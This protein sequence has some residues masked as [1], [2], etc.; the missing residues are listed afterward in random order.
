[1]DP[2]DPHDQVREAPRPGPRRP[3]G[4][5]GARR[6][7]RRRRHDEGHRH[8]RRGQSHDGDGAHRADGPEAAGSDRHPRLQRVQRLRDRR[9]GAAGGLHGHQGRRGRDGPRLRRR[10]ARRRGPPGR[11]GPLG[12]LQ[13]V[14]AARPL[15]RRGRRGR[16]HRDRDHAGRLRPD[17]H[18]VRAQVRRDQ[19]RAL[20]QDQREEPRP[21]DAEPARG[22]HEEDVARRDHERRHDRL[23]QHRGRCARPTATGRRRPWSC[24]APS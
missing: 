3:G 1:M 15:R 4:G 24:R 6:A 10:E 21:F 16:A 17:R 11:R 20:R 22:L 2:R 14:D 7:G 9:D 12:G 18:G 8:H 19:L 23:P 13:H 5:G